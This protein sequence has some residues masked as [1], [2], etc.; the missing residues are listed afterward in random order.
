MWIFILLMLCAGL[1]SITADMLPLPCPADCKLITTDSLIQCRCA[2]DT[3]ISSSCY[4]SFG[5]Y[6]H[7]KSPCEFTSSKTDKFTVTFAWNNYKDCGGETSDPCQ[8]FNGTSIY[9]DFNS[10]KLIEPFAWSMY[11]FTANTG[12]TVYNLFA[13]SSDRS[14]FGRLLVSPVYD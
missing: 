1:K 2:D 9:S 10:F 7:A 6:D 3:E 8:Y 12:T 4:V 11:N 5:W 14:G 13:E